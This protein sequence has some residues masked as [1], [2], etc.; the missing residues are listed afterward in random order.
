MYGNLVL[1]YCDGLTAIVTMVTIAT[2]P[3]RARLRPSKL[4]MVP[5]LPSFAFHAC[6]LT[7]LTIIN[8]TYAVHRVEVTR[9]H[10]KPD[11][12]L[13]PLNEST[14]SCPLLAVHLAKGPYRLRWQPRPT[15]SDRSLPLLYLLIAGDI[16]PIPGPV[17]PRNRPR[18]RRRPTLPSCPTCDS[19]KGWTKP[20]LQCDGW[21]RWFHSACIGI[22]S[23]EYRTLE[24]DTEGEWF[25]CMCALP[26]GNHSLNDNPSPAAVR[27][28]DF[29]QD[30]S[31][32]MPK[33]T[34]RKTKIGPQDISTVIVNANS[35]KGKKL[36]LGALISTTLPHILII[37]ETKLSSKI[38]SAEF[39]DTQNYSVILKDRNAK[40]GG[41]LIAISNELDGYQ[42]D[43]PCES[44]SVY[45]VIHSRNHPPT[46]I[47]AVYRPPDHKITYLKTLLND[48]QATVEAVKP[49]HILLG[50]DFN[51]PRISLEEGRLQPRAPHRKQAKVLMHTMEKLHLD[52]IIDILT[53]GPNT[54]DL[55]F[56]DVPSL[57]NSVSSA[58]G[59]SDHDT[60]IVKH[61][62]KASINKKAERQVP[63]FHKANWTQLKEDLHLFRDDYLGSKPCERSITTNWYLIKTTIHKLM[64][65]HIPQKSVGT[66][67]NL[68]Y[69]TPA[70]KRKIRRRHRVYKKAKKRGRKK[71][72]EETQKLRKEI[73]Q[74]LQ[75]AYA[76]YIN[77]LLDPEEDKPGAIKRFYR[78]IKHLR[79]ESTGVSTLKAGG[80]ISAT[81]EEK[82]NACN[83]QF[84]S[85]FS[86][87]DQATMPQPHGERFPRM[88]DLNITENGV[89]KLLEGLN[90]SKASGPDQVPA[91]VL[92]ECAKPLAPVIADFYQQSIDEARLP[93]DWK[94]QYVHP[95][96]KKGSRSD[97]ANY[98]PVA[99][100]CILCKTLEHIIASN[101]HCHLEEHGFLSDAQHGFRKLR[102]CETQLYATLQDFF[103][104]LEAGGRLDAVVLDFSKAF[105]KV[106]HERLMSKL[107]HC[108]VQG[109]TRRWIR[110]WLIGREEWVVVESDT[111][112]VT[113]GVPQGSVLGPLLFLIFINDIAQDLNSNIRL[114]A[115]DALLYRSIRSQE[116][117]N[118]MQEDLDTLAHWASTWCMEFNVTK[119]YAMHIM[120]TSQKKQAVCIP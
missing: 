111:C 84:Q 57:V 99:L 119:C 46:L 33:Y 6:V 7:L 52:Q 56:T 105:D 70:I 37:T 24:A 35:V 54:L 71:D 64:T 31:T 8:M 42:A 26:F 79:Q 68:P 41:V 113:S 15:L 61:R 69:I 27:N 51:L 11:L 75:K 74:E 32:P 28:P 50:G 60:I 58:P 81:A 65:R 49:V 9:G 4:A 92:K 85:A 18:R 90:P 5:I 89:L 108:G 63:L 93:Y 100:T 73:N 78:Y 34:L 91:R 23:G 3:H 116:D 95:V 117:H 83:A 59:L 25:C 36:Q 97:P 77:R 29:P 76:N 62:L 14:Q 2:P 20:A 43:V 38:G 16:H 110:H 106:P 21:D 17:R 80:K 39:I 120:T 48:L 45:V 96:F 66:R 44:E 86:M 10:M 40:G 19:K 94:Q 55:L 112:S 30:H 1:K 109:S 114:F 101:L 22:T 13:T 115:D 107:L 67:F 47:G 88:P 87:E 102:S 103:D 118:R 104:T 82:A 12:T 72:W 98:R 53:R